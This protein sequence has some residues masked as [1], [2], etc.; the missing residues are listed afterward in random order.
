MKYKLSVTPQLKKLIKDGYITKKISPCGKLYLLNYTD[1]TTYEDKWNMYTLNARGNVYEVG[2]DIIVARSFPKFFNLSQHAKSRQRA[3]LKDDSFTAY[4]KADGSLGICFHYDGEW[5]VSTRG[6]FTSEQ[7]VKAKQ[8]LNAKYNMSMVPTD[9]TILVEIIYPENRIVVNYGDEEKLVLLA[10]YDNVTMK[11]TDGELTSEIT[12]IPRAKQY[13][14][15]SIKEMVELQETLTKDEEGF[16]VKLKD[17]MRVK[18]KGKEYL[19]VHRIL[20]NLTPLN[21]WRSMIDGKVVIEMETIPE[22]V[23]DEVQETIDQLET[24]YW[25][26]YWECL[27]EYKSLNVLYEI[28]D[29]KSLGLTIKEQGDKLKHSGSLFPQFHGKSI[30]SYIMKLIKPVGNEL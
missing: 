30:D 3:I 13:H 18:I 11:E 27:T 24:K 22:E 10:V 15:D 12:G 26:T 23:R 1:K 4:E 7:A 29:A 2:T 9:M 25:K 17:G 14:F 6:S 8:L 28:T 5:R 21:F 20:A 19:R 16:V